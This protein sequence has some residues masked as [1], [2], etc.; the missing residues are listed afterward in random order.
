MQ[1]YNAIGHAVLHSQGANA[2]LTLI[3]LQARIT[4]VSFMA[5]HLLG[6]VGK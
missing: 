5:V 2:R 1:L 6:L 3:F 4:I